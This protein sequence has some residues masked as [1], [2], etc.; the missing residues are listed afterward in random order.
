MWGAFQFGWHDGFGADAD[1]L[2]AI[3]DLN[4]F[5]K[6]GYSFFTIDPGEYVDN[7]AE[8]LSEKELQAKPRRAL[9]RNPMGVL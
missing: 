2:K 7:S 5:I 1:H 3:D 9:A 8:I 4:D 6:G